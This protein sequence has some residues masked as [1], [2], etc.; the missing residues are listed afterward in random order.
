MNYLELNLMKINKKYPHIC[1]ELQKHNYDPE[2]Y[3]FSRMES[4]LGNVEYTL[5]SSSPQLLFENN[6]AQLELA[7]WVQ[8]LSDALSNHDHILL[9]GLGLG[10]H[11]RLLLDMYPNKWIYVY[12]PDMDLFITALIN[13]DL[14][15]ILDHPNVKSM[16]VGISM[17]QRRQLIFPICQLAQGT[18]SVVRLPFHYK[19]RMGEIQGFQQVFDEIVTEY[20]INQNTLIRFKDIWMINRFNHFVTN[21]SSLSLF[22][23]KG[24]FQNT[25]A[26]IVGSGPSLELDINWIRELKDYCLIIA[27]GSSVQALL[28]H[29]ITP[30]LVVVID[31]GPVVENIFLVPGSEKVPL[32]YTPSANYKATDRVNAVMFHA[33]DDTDPVTRYF[34]ETDKEEPI[35]RSLASVSGTAVQAAVYMGCSDIIFA[36]QDFSFPSDKH[37]SNGVAHVHEVHQSRAISQAN[38]WVENVSGS[39]NRTTLPYKI[40]LNKMEE[41]LSWFPEV[42]FIN[43][44][45][46]GAK[47]EGTNWVPIEEIIDRLKNTNDPDPDRFEKALVNKPRRYNPTQIEDIVNKIKRIAVEIERISE[48]TR[49]ILRLLRKL[50]EL[51]RTNPRK[52]ENTMVVVEEIW[53]SIVD[54]EIFKTL[55]E[56]L[57]PEELQFFDNH[58][59]RIISEENIHDKSKYFVM[60]LGKIVREIIG[61]QPKLED[62]Y[63]ISIERIK[64]SN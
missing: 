59:S 56:P 61:I 32:L 53:S 46:L 8:S 18:C 39:S 22:Q 62:L 51:S 5:P 16:A 60:Y 25:P 10:Y 55:Y 14:R 40:L 17:G 41:V 54:G 15:D 43:T 64:R 29:G 63:R 35:L 11:L 58:L 23:L 21:L 49:K 26:L 9:Y 37:Y 44:S 2:V 20:K 30:H 48:K 34:F 36:G 50:E 42:N 6:D 33:Y 52:C 24:M 27:A 1:M 3:H 57:L 13:E 31:G 4:G 19:T 47:I 38:I 7:L 28:Q 45:K 12:E